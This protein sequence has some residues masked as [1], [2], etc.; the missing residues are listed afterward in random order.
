MRPQDDRLSCRDH[1]HR[2]LSEEEPRRHH[3]ART[4]QH[5]AEEFERRRAELQ[6]VGKIIDPH[7]AQIERL[8]TEDATL[9]ARILARDQQIEDL[10]EFKALGISRL[11]AQHD[12]IERLRRQIAEIGPVRQLP[13]SASRKAPYGS[14]S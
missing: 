6:E 4:Y 2:L 8:K 5:L 13:R 1:P 11:A 7:D 9:K 14:S 3:P 10:S 12:E